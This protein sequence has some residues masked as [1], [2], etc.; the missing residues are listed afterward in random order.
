M[1]AAAT[2]LCFFLCFYGLNSQQD[3]AREIVSEFTPNDLPPLSAV[4]ENA[5]ITESASQLDHEQQV[6]LGDA[7]SEISRLQRELDAS[8]N[9]LSTSALETTKLTSAIA[10]LELKLQIQ[11]EE[12]TKI[13]A[14]LDMMK[15]KLID[16]TDEVNRLQEELN[17][18]KNQ[19]ATGALKVAELSSTI[20]K[21]E[22][23]LA[24][25]RDA[26]AVLKERL[27]MDLLESKDTNE[28]LR[29]QLLSA[30][31]IIVQLSNQLD[32]IKPA[33]STPLLSYSLE[34]IMENAMKV[35]KDVAMYIQVTLERLP[36][37]DK[38]LSFLALVGDKA[39]Q[40]VLSLKES[41]PKS[42][43]VS[44][45][46][47][48]SLARR[49][50]SSTSPMISK[51]NK[52]WLLCVETIMNPQRIAG[53]ISLYEPYLKNYVNKGKDLLNYLHRVVYQPHLA[54][55]VD[56]Y[57]SPSYEFVRNKLHY[58][59]Y[60]TL[61]AFYD[62]NIM[63]KIYLDGA[64]LGSK[65]TTSVDSLASHLATHSIVVAS[66]GPS[67]TDTIR[68]CIY[69]LLLITAVLFHGPVF[70]LLLLCVKL[71]LLPFTLIVRL[72]FAFLG[73][74][75]PFRRTRQASYVSHVTT[76]RP[77]VNRSPFL[78]MSNGNELNSS[79]GNK[80]SKGASGGLPSVHSN[81]LHARGAPSN[82]LCLSNM[83]SIEDLK[84]DTLYKELFE[85]V[86]HECGLYGTVR[87]V[88]IP[89]P[90]SRLTY[91][92]SA[93]V[94]NGIGKVFVHFFE[95]KG[96]MRAKAA[97]DGRRYDSKTLQVAFF[98]EEAFTAKVTLLLE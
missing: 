67:A 61:V 98:P 68:V 26:S 47:D 55:Y 66:L 33:A 29:N 53:A 79:G 42:W 19:L 25:S 38:A 86:Q 81:G 50:I 52:I 65:F 2:I 84:D 23:K 85:D 17:V 91:N 27:E 90:H 77:A 87:E 5:H 88:R 74:L 60:H 96:A 35:L 30:Q 97:L 48:S 89:R 80:E 11:N 56:N 46:R 10:E 54:L 4:P 32:A 70:W 62:D 40:A 6:E 49:A 20:S 13:S 1:R 41:L 8:K 24:E 57:L 69:L 64:R 71:I 72:T 95:I 58:I 83:I 34:M 3:D 73:L 59:A 43:N 44:S 76:A 37:Y 82:V 28:I 93:S 45:I 94:K 36:Y 14:K 63:Q 51:V 92:E 75:N 22:A 31:D 18:S 7:L 78:N 15:A 39:Q 12:S 16:S 9:Q 21:L